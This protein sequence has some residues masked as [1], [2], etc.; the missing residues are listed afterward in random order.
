VDRSISEFAGE[1]GMPDDFFTTLDTWRRDL[2]SLK[3]VIGP[4]VTPDQMIEYEAAH[5]EE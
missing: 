1:K 2:L 3:S 4:I 5:L